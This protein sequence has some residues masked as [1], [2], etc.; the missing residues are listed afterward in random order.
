MCKEKIKQEKEIT[1]M[2]ALNINKTL[3]SNVNKVSDKVSLK[4]R[5]VNYIMENS[6]IIISGLST[7]NGNT[8]ALRVYAM[9]KNGR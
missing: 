9:M 1:I 4:E 2:T 6:D 3:T 7:L 5:F 8:N